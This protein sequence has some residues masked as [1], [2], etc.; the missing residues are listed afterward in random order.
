MSLVE[1]MLSIYNKQKLWEDNV[2]HLIYDHAT[3]QSYPLTFLWLSFTE[4]DLKFLWQKCDPSLVQL[5]CKKAF[6]ILK[7]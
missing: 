3:M 6:Q 7:S 5:F 4:L 1:M 2:S